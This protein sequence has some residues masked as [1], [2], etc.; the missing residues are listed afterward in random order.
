LSTHRLDT[1]WI[2]QPAYNGPL[3][4]VRR[5]S[6]NATTNIGLL[7]AGGFANAAAQDSLC[8]NT[9]CVITIIFDQTT[10]HNDLPIEPAG[11]A[12]PANDTATSWAADVTW[13][14]TTPWTP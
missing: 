8:A 1:A 12:G 11:T 4:Q 13:A 10:R 2:A 9:S 7:T 5:A 3:Y 14:V 6:D